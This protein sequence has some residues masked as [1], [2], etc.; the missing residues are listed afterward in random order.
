MS[1]ARGAF[2]QLQVVHALVMRE[3]RTRFGAH[4]LGYLW[5][6]LEPVLWIATFYALFSLAERSA[7]SGM[8]VASFLATGLIPYQLFR[9]VISRVVVAVNANRGLLFYPQVRPLDLAVARVLL[10][11]ATWISVFAILVSAEALYRGTLRVDN[12]L[13]VLFGFGLSAWLGGALGMILGALS[14]YLPSI[15]K[16]SGA[17]IRPLF[18]LSGVFFTANAVPPKM[19]EVIRYNPVLHCIEL[20][21]DGWFPEYTSLHVDVTYPVAVGLVLALFGMIFERASRVR[22]ELT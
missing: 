9:E 8:T 17:L 11:T 22:I 21:R 7:P 2:V 10:E 6:L 1:L 4:Q 15:E 3:T 19:L 18:W 20:V 13:M 5:A 16:F 12:L 14:L